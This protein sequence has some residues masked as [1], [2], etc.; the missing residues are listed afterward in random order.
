[1]RSPSAQPC[2]R[3][4]S[5]SNQISVIPDAIAQCPA[6]QSLNLNSN[7]ISVIPDAIAQCPALQIAQPSDSNQISVIPDVIAQCPALQSL[8]LSS[9]QISVIP[10][11]IAQCPA[12][13]SLYLRLESNQRHSRCDRPVPSPAIARP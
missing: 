11:V 2:K 1:M 10:D 12:L 4:T 7:Q 13:Q 9:N 3:S 6:L 5:S 8:D